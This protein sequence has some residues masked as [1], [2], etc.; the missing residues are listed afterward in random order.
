MNENHSPKYGVFAVSFSAYEKSVIERF[1]C[2]AGQR[3]PGWWLTDQIEEAAVVLVSASTVQQV[4]ACYPLISPRQKVVIIGSSDFGTGWAFLPR[5]IKLMV[6]LTKLGE[7]LSLGALRRERY[8]TTPL[9]LEPT[10]IAQTVV[11]PALPVAPQTTMSIGTAR[12]FEAPKPLASAVAGEMSKSVV[13]PVVKVSEKAPVIPAKA[14]V[15]V[16]DDSQVALKF[17]Q[18]RLRQFGYEGQLAR[19]GEEALAMVAAEDF[20]FVF[21]DVMMSGLD[22]YQTCKA[23]KQNKARKN[24]PV[25]V[26][27]T[28][29]GGTIDK[30]RGSMAGCDA[31]LTK[32][33]NERQLA[34]VLVKHDPSALEETQFSDGASR[35]LMSDQRRDRDR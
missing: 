11:S 28:S 25:V 2:I 31:Y 27:L 35:F 4:D 32:P 18:N 5:P 3:P 21:L 12:S 7:L 20:K 17:M 14:R 9:G 24:T 6:I 33:L 26:M 30:I 8:V 22:G 23:I 29:R 15:L 16:V 13:K 1:F 19:G 34:A 10:A